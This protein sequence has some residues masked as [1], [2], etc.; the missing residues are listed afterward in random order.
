MAAAAEHVMAA[1]EAVDIQAAVPAA[2]AVEVMSLE[3][4]PQLSR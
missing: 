3:H 2:E 1:A 4:R